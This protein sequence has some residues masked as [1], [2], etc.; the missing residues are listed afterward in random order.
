M[1]DYIIQRRKSEV[2]PAI[3]TICSFTPTEVITTDESPN[4][5][6][7][8]VFGCAQYRR[9]D[10]FA[11]IKSNVTAEFENDEWFLSEIGPATQLDGPE[12]GC[13]PKQ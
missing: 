6:A 4:G 2:T 9:A 8:V 13:T 1:E 10:G 12:E 3:S 11:W 7:W 5:G